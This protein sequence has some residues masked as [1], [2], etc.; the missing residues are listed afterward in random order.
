MKTFAEEKEYFRVTTNPLGLRWGYV[1]KNPQSI[2]AD[3]R[4]F[5]KVI[6]SAPFMYSPGMSCSGSKND[7]QGIFPPH[8][9]RFGTLVERTQ[10]FAVIRAHIIDPRWDDVS[11]LLLSANNSQLIPAKNWER[12][13]CHYNQFFPVS[14][15]RDLFAYQI[16]AGERGNS[17]QYMSTIWNELAVQIRTL[18]R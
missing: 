3:I 18:I 9:M 4:S 5:I 15:E 12:D 1:D 7:H 10:G 11:N 16:F 6:N 17:N 8:N 14:T 13:D 2:D